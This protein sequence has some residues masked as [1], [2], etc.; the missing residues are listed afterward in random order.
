MRSA[1]NPAG[2]ETF[3]VAPRASFSVS[4]RNLFG[5]DRS[6]NLFTRV[7]FR[8]GGANI[9]D[10][11]SAV[12]QNGSY[13]FNE[14]LARLAYGERRIFG[15][16]ADGTFAGG[17]EQTRRTSFTFNRRSA[18]VTLARRAFGA[19]LPPMLEPIV[20][21]PARPVLVESDGGPPARY[22]VLG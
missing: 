18:N 3:Q 6:L 19:C 15:T 5:K 2:A 12:V 4:R 21:T 13:G 11:T 14:Y 10:S 9:S 17:I 7:S 16:P 20:W 1:E 8:Q 22:R